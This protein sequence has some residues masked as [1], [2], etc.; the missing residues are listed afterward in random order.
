MN[1]TLRS[2]EV[3]SCR[4]LCILLVYDKIVNAYVVLYY[5]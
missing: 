2:A 1:L 5:L 3:Y 4:T